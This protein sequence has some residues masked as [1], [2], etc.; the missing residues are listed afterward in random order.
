MAWMLFLRSLDPVPALDVGQ[1]RADGCPVFGIGGDMETYFIHFFQ[2]GKELFAL[3]QLRQI[4]DQHK[5]LDGTVQC[6]QDSRLPDGLQ[7]HVDDA[8]CDVLGGSVSVCFTEIGCGGIQRKIGE[9]TVADIL[10]LKID[11]V[12][13]SF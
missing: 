6:R 3:G 8:R 12:Q 5:V 7:N 13:G 4:A 10:Y 1:C 9:R 11:R 2:F